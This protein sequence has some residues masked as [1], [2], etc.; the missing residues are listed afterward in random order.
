VEGWVDGSVPNYGVLLTGIDTLLEF[1][2]YPSEYNADPSLRP[3]L[4]VDAVP[5]PPRGT[6]LVI[7]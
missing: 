6:V 1:R 2:F 7:Q 5:I 4:V 3:K